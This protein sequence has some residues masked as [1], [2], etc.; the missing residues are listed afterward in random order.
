MEIIDYIMQKYGIVPQEKLTANKNI[1]QE[2][3]VMMEGK[4]QKNGRKT[5]K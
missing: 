1:R 5:E 3:V 4:Q 2:N